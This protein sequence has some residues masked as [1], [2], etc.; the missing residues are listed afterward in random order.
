M[1]EDAVVLLAVL[2]VDEGVLEL[3]VPGGGDALELVAVGELELDLERKAP[4]LKLVLFAP[5]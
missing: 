2:L 5:V 3:G 1:L 4:V